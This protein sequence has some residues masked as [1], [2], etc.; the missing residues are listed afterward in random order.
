MF[1]VEPSAGL[2][3]RMGVA[4][5]M[6]LVVVVGVHEGRVHRA[7]R[8]PA[9]ILTVCDGVTG[10]RVQE[11]R[12]YTDAECD[13]MVQEVLDEH[14]FPVL[15]CL[16][17][18]PPG[19]QLA[20]VD[21]AYNVGVRE[22]CGGQVAAYYR[23]GR[24]EDVCR[25]IGLYTFVTIRGVKVN[26]RLAGKTCPGIVRRR[27]VEQDYCTGRIRIPHLFDGVTAGVETS[28]KGV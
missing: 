4:A 27:Q 24:Y 10:S 16:G 11:G 14:A 23:M 2:V 15:D 17:R 19:V 26:C 1:H 25:R 9:G 12:V 7:Y 18:G 20:L 13:R 22:V 6:V 21:L 5:A 8:D 28:V 3:K